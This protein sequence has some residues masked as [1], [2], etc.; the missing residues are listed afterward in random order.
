MGSRLPSPSGSPS[1]EKFSSTDPSDD[2]EDFDDGFDSIAH[3]IEAMTDRDFFKDG[4]EDRT[5]RLRV[6]C[7]MICQTD[8]K[9]EQIMAEETFPILIRVIKKDSGDSVTHA[10]RALAAA[11]MVFT[12]LNGM[13]TGVKDV[14]RKCILQS[15]TIT[16]KVMA[17]QTLGSVAF[18]GGAGYDDMDSVMDLFFQIIQTD[19]ESAN[20]VDNVEIVVAAIEQWSFLST[21]VEPD[22]MKFNEVLE[23]LENQLESSSPEVLLA[24]ADGIGLLCEQQYE[25]RSLD[26]WSRP[27]DDG[28]DDAKFADTQDYILEQ[29]L[30]PRYRKATWEQNHDF[31]Q[32]NNHLIREKLNDI[33]SSTMRQ[34]RK[35]MRRE[36]HSTFRDVVHT[37][38]FPWRGP[39]FSTALSDGEGTKMHG[40]RLF[41]NGRTIDRWWKLHR[42]NAI[43]RVLRGGIGQHLNSGE[44]AADCLEGDLTAP[45][46]LKDELDAQDQD[47][48][49]QQPSYG[50]LEVERD[51]DASLTQ[52]TGRLRLS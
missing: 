36:L 14:V 27:Q 50:D 28:G 47:T 49:L 24:V 32:G 42:Y 1:R 13:F 26:K 19:G 18:F 37:I 21:L 22:D 4:V 5:D 7:N 3:I 10:L 41:R 45:S 34:H 29:G 25:P 38:D 33:A 52:R 51:D 9:P 20:A 31:F 17:I 11:P 40:H 23:A 12:P 15:E 16:N 46:R 48:E 2:S 8:L 43:K 39:R 44:P 30:P 35:D 6:F